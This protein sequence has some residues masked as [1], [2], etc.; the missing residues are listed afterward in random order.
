MEEMLSLAIRTALDEMGAENVPFSVE[1]PADLA[2]GDFA[3]NAALAAAKPLGRSPREIA[4]ELAGKLRDALGEQAASVEVAGPGF[5][6]VTLARD[7]IASAIRSV[8]AEGWG[9]GSARSEE[10]IAFEYSCP[11]P[12]KEMHVGHVMSAVIGEA[13]SRIIENQGAR[14]LRDTYGG[15]VG[16]HVAKALWALR[17][18]GNENPA[19]PKEIGEAYA[20]GSHAYEESEE[21]KAEIDAL[22]VS[23][24]EALAKEEGERSD[25][26]R[27]L[28]ELWRHGRDASLAAHGVIWDAL[29]THFDYILHE[30]ETTP[31]GIAA[32]REALEKGVFVESQGAVIY[33]GEKK[34]LHTLVFLTSRGTPT[35]EAKDI[36]LAFLKEERMGPLDRVYITTAAEQKGHF[37]VFLAALS[38][39]APELAAKTKHVPHGFLRL[40]TGKMSSREGNVITG[41]GL[42]SEIIDT[43]Q[44]K[45]EDPLVAKAVAIGAIKYMILR[46]AAGGDIIFD[47]EKSLSL[48]GDSGPYLQYALVR[49]RSVLAQA[50]KPEDIEAPLEP[51]ALERLI[52]RFP[53]VARR[54]EAEL[55]PHKVAQYLTQLAG[56]WNSFYANNRIIGGEHEGYKLLLA[57]AFA[58]TM[59]RGL[60]LLGIPVPERM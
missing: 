56:E 17:R 48:D 43:A 46:Q 50:Q 45:N 4:D 20:Q 55:A 16:P 57:R 33:N 15:D 14:V 12:F 52:I 28:L 37:E 19:T 44:E 53:E 25:E 41:A 2:H 31:I 22:N 24:Y 21:A 10:R 3:T 59:E 40:T 60:N 18:K 30:S 27:A 51:Y 42:I 34:G 36:G 49:A 23:L 54:A 29:G 38:D 7:A 13:A 58:L 9:S 35:Y 26:D 32:V 39:I 47:P 5:V 6:N 11:N 1:W 8:P